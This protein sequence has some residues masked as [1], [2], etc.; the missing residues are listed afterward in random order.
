MYLA[1]SVDLHSNHPK[2]VYVH[3]HHHALLT[4]LFAHSRMLRDSAVNASSDCDVPLVTC[5]KQREEGDFP[6]MGL[7]PNMPWRPH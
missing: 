7:S 6:S 2:I 3:T 5:V 4:T 1:L